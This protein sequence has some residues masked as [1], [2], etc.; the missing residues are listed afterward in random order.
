MKTVVVLALDRGGPLVPLGRTHD[1]GIATEV[2]RRILEDVRLAG[3]Q[4]DDEIMRTLLEQEAQ[5]L[6]RAF[7]VVGLD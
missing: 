4:E 5:R 7:T 2:A 6:Q 1:Q 3:A